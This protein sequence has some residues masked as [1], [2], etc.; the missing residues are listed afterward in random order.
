[1][2]WA[3]SPG[4]SNL[5]EGTM[6]SKQVAITVDSNNNLHQIWLWRGELS[7]CQKTVGWR[8]QDIGTVTRVG[9]WMGMILTSP[10]QGWSELMRLLLLIMFCKIMCIL[11]C[12][13]EEIY[14]DSLFYQAI[15]LHVCLINLTLDWIQ[16]SFSLNSTWFPTLWHTP[17]IPH[18]F[19][20]CRS[21]DPQH[22]LPFFSHWQKR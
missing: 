10:W 9:V 12:W 5:P 22:N 4:R 13:H 20:T 6:L 17:S 7:L 14:E 1:M 11:F 2:S 8:K 19:F 3:R 21:H 16:S 15:F 18:D